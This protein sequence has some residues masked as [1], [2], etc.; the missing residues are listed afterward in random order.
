MKCGFLTPRLEGLSFSA[1]MVV[2]ELQLRAWNSD[3]G[4]FMDLT[5]IY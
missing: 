5:S 1:C 3:L 2:F 4:V